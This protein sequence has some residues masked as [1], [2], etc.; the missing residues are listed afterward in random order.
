MQIPPPL[1]QDVMIEEGT[2]VAAYRRPP[3]VE[4]SV[5]RALAL[6]I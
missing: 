6:H 4:I 5:P 2:N 1:A 3:G